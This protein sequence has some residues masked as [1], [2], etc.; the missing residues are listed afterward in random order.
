MRMLWKTSEGYVYAG[1]VK[2]AHVEWK[3]ANRRL[4]G[5]VTVN[6]EDPLVLTSALPVEVLSSEDHFEELQQEARARI[7]KD[8]DMAAGRHLRD[9]IGVPTEEEIAE[10][11]KATAVLAPGYWMTHE[12]W[13]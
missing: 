11:E 4:F 10:F 3:F 5:K 7:F 6:Q 9:Y 13:Q 12:A 1:A 8:L 2:H